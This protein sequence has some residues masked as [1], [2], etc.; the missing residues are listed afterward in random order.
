MAK[1]PTKEHKPTCPVWTWF[2]TG[3]DKR[4][5][6]CTCKESHV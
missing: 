3:G 2:M 6:L 4:K 1:A 5:P